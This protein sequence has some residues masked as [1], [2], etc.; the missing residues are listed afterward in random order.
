[1]PDFPRCTKCGFRHA[2]PRF[3]ELKLQHQDPCDREPRTLGEA[4]V[5]FLDERWPPQ[6]ATEPRR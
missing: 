2:I 3:R 6:D 4:M 1:M 5:D